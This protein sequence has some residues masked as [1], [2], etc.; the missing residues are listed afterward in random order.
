MFETPR[1]LSDSCG[2]GSFF[3]YHIKEPQHW[4]VYQ[5]DR[6]LRNSQSY[7]TKR[8]VQQIIQFVEQSV[9][10]N[11]EKNAPQ[12]RSTTKQIA[13]MN[14][15]KLDPLNSLLG[16]KTTKIHY[17]NTLGN[18]KKSVAER[19]RHQRQYERRVKKDRCSVREFETHLTTEPM[20]EVQLTACMQ[21]LAIGQQRMSNQN[22]LLKGRVDQTG[23]KISLGHRFSPNKTF[24]VYEKT[25]PRSDLRWKP[26]GRILNNV[27]LRWVPTGK[28]FTSCTSKDDS[29]STHGSNVDIPNIHECK[30]T[31][32]LSADLRFE[33]ETLSGEFLNIPDHKS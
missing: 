23:S 25:S 30:Q 26:T 5:K 18:V 20:A 27:G 16:G 9:T 24:A 15:K 19:T 33:L 29:E 14:F 8:L 3:D 13:K 17:S 28:I 11:K 12:C 10:F 31:L 22:S 6:V 4:W 1:A 7:A 21:Y 2:C 32:D